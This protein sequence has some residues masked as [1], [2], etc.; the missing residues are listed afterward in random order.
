MKSSI[1]VLAVGL[2]SATIGLVAAPAA[3]AEPIAD[4]YRGKTMEFVVGAAAGGAT[5]FAA[6]TVA[7]YLGRHIPGNPTIIV[8]NMPGATGLI[9]TNYLYNVAKRDG[10]VLGMTLSNELLEPRLKL[11]SADGSAIKFD[12]SRMNWVGTPMQEPQVTW[13]W[14]TAP[15]KSVS[16]LKKNTIL[17]GATGAEADNALLP[18]LTN[19]L[20]GTHMK[21]ITGY[22][23]QNAINLAVERGE[24]QGNNTGL[25][26]LTTLKAGWLRDGKIRILLQWGAE[27]LASI[28]DVPTMVE[29][30]NSEEDRAM[31][32]FY[33][34][35]FMMARPIALPPGVPAERVAA[36]DSAFAATMKDSQ[37][38]EEARR[39]GLDTNWLGSAKMTKQLRQVQETPQPVVDRLRAFLTRAGAK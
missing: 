12:I 10:T 7:K 3:Y 24:I 4:F 27:R 37:Y 16:D 30:V 25:S 38:L 36:L 34:L 17:M 33:A 28:P 23:G 9:M 21:V 26:N 1:P 20:L 39:I 11:L 13:V 14:Q 19:Q 32:R 31:L 18:L 5:D 15:A 2:L 35:K 22:E 8:R 6:R 29:L